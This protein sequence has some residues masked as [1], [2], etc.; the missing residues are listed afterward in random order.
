METNI[1]PVSKEVLLSVRCDPEVK[2]I[3]RVIGRM[4][5]RALSGVVLVAIDDYLVNW[6]TLHGPEALAQLRA[7]AKVGAVA[8]VPKAKK[9]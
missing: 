5:R 4:D 8:K 1:N 9:V 3:L 6:G 2:R 7:E